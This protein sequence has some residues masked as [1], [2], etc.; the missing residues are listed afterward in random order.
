MQSSSELLNLVL[1]L[2]TKE[3]A[4]IA[5]EL[6]H[7]LDPDTDE[8]V[9]AAWEKEIDARLQKI[10]A[11]KHKTHDWRAAIDEIRQELRKES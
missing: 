9:A 11:G 10:A 5:H 2:P 7:S 6:L 8:G 4:A 3:R 1:Q